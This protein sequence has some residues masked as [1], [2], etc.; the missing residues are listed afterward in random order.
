MLDPTGHWLA[1]FD[2]ARLGFWELPAGRPGASVADDTFGKSLRYC[3]ESALVAFAPGGAFFAVAGVV[4]KGMSKPAVLLLSPETGRTIHLLKIPDEASSPTWFGRLCVSRDGHRVAYVG[5]SSR[6][7]VIWDAGTGDVEQILPVGDT[8]P[9]AERPSNGSIEFSPDG[10]RLAGVASPGYRETGP[11]SETLLIWDLDRPS[12][13]DPIRISWKARWPL[14]ARPIHSGIPL[15]ICPDGRRL[16]LVSGA[17]NQPS[18][19]KLCDWQGRELASWALDAPAIAAAF[20]PDGLRL[21][22]AVYDAKMGTARLVVFDS[23]PIDPALEADELVRRFAGGL[24]K[25]DLA[26][27][28]AAEPGYSPA[29][30]REAAR[31]ASA[32]RGDAE[33]L[34]TRGQQI[35]GWPGTTTV[36]AEQARAALPYLEEAVRADS[37]HLGAQRA[38]GRALYL[39]GRFAEAR[40]ALSR[41][42]RPEPGIAISYAYLA[43]AEARLGRRAE[44]ERALAE[45]RRLSAEGSPG[46][47]APPSLLAEVESVLRESS[48][49]GAGGTGSPRLRD[50]PGR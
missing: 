22:V 2:D 30:R 36:T 9:V 24:L 38:L 31:I 17:M 29:V 11:R 32:R 7:V 8:R 46:P 33:A 16:A 47:L 27:R 39:A 19:V 41:G 18:E 49:A 14:P 37:D 42:V 10:R 45:C 20:T 25:E 34:V 23:T 5:A 1:F 4:P 12:G 15:C 26:R 28:V 21:I 40:D 43:M 44:A 13:S 50:R 3:F 48:A 35:L 6:A